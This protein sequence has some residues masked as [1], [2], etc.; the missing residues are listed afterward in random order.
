MEI[1]EVINNNIGTCTKCGRGTMNRNEFCYRHRPA[2][3]NSLKA[4]NNRYK[5][6][7]KGKIA[8][9]NA[10]RNY[11]ERKRAANNEVV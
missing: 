8:A 10:A 1:V 11:R 9:R 6:S 4:A 7:E 2:D 5:Q 3:I